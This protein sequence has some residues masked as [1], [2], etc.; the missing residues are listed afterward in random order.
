[1]EKI[2]LSLSALFPG[3]AFAHEEHG[4]T[5]KENTWH[6]L[7]SPEH[8]WPLTIAVALV[9]IVGLVKLRS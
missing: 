1:M 8:A 2:I 7:A 4:V 9:V 3:F 6:V 5:L